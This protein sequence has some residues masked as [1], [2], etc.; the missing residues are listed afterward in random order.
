M[1]RFFRRRPDFSDDAID[2]VLAHQGR[3]D[4]ELGIEEEYTFNIRPKGTRTNAGYISFRVGESPGLYYLGHIGYRVEMPHR[5]K[6]YAARA[7]LLLMPLMREEGFRSV[8]ITTNEDNMPSRKTCEKINCVL[9]NIV[10]VPLEFQDLCMGARSKCR[11]ILLLQEG[12]D[13][14]RQK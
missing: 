2:L 9:E 8:V 13:T 7:V 1:F 4:E 3:W 12:A 6:G 14:C 11:Y 10:P 5:G